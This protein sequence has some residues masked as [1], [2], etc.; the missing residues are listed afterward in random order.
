MSVFI[1]NGSNF[2]V[3]SEE[4]LDIHK[5][6]PV[7]SYTIKKDSFGVFFFESIEPFKMVGKIY[8]DTLKNVDRMFNTFMARPKTTGIMLSGEKGS[9]KTLLAKALSVKCAEEGIPTIVI[10]TAWHGEEF[11]TLI[12]A[13]EQPCVILFDEFEKVYDSQEQEAVLTLLDGVFPSKKLFILTCN[14]SWR[15]DRH[16]R[17]RP[18]R[19]FYLVD[20]KGLDVNFITEYCQ[21]NLKDKSEIENVCRISVLFSEFNFDMLKALCE[22]MN[23]YDESAQEAMKLLNAKPSSDDGGKYKVRLIV[24]GDI[25]PEDQTSPK[26]W[27]GNP[28]ATE[29]FTVGTCSPGAADKEDEDN[30]VIGRDFTSSSNV[31]SFKF[32]HRHLK[33]VD[34]AA[35]TFSYTNEN[36]VTVVFTK[37]K[38]E[39]TYSA[40]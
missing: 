27:N 25:I 33:K 7:G 14:D 31:G 38:Q 19:I 29:Q 30:A 6:L 13:I 4:N 36:G 9:G 17:N 22:E 12:Q 5:T 23:R 21:E 8:G 28:L 26:Q 37:M 18:G 11:N 3:A 39:F 24:D 10:N 20:F 35:G 16:M 15:I 34:P 32:T 1:K 2:R 40:F